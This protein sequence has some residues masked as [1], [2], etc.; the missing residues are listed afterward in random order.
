MGLIIIPALFICGLAALVSLMRAIANQERVWA[1]RKLLVAFAVVLLFLVE[2]FFLVSSNIEE[3]KVY[4][5]AIC[6]SSLMA[7]FLQSL[8]S[9]ALSFIKKELAWKMS[10]VLA[11]AA[12]LTVLLGLFDLIFPIAQ[13]LG[14]KRTF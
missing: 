9:F 1:G 10:Y 12:A 11:V 6:I 4:A 13:I 5:F 14:L 2:L 8:A 7:S 3:G